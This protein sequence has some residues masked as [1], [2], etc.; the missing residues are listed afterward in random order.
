MAITFIWLVACGGLTLVNLGPLP[1]GG[2][3]TWNAVLLL[4]CGL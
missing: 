3:I 4:L 2:D 1:I